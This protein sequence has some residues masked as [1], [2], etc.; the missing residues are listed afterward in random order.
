MPADLPSDLSTE[1][2]GWL[3][4]IEQCSSTNTWAIEHADQL[5]HGDVVFTQHQTAGR[6]QHGRVWYAPAGVLTASFVLDYLPV[7]RLSGLSLAAGLATIY[8][9]EDLLALDFHNK[10]KLKWP[11]DILCGGTHPER[12]R[13]KLAGILCE[14]TSK[15]SSHAR[16][17]V[18]IGLN[19]SVDFA[20]L[21]LETHV[22]MD[23]IANA[24]S[25]HQISAVVPDQLTLLERLR[26]YL[27]E[28]AGL[29]SRTDIPAS[30]TGLA[31]LQSELCDRDA[32]FG[33][34]ITL[35]LATKTISGKAVGIDRSGQLLLRLS[36]GQV[37]AFSSG[38]V[39][40]G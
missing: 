18:G 34:E 17:I 3:R 37:R 7:A 39:R 12:N 23:A 30:D 20:E 13:R 27:L 19:L 15:Q 40:W 33:S 32:L 35:E 29:F 16:V 1:L 36:D 25:L 14:A 26:H 8:A 4:W 31:L 9:V 21:G 5:Q 2:P 28:M 22:D 10:L 24:V 38:R 11:N 6:G